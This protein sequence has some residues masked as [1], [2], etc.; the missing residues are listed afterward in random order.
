MK[1]SNRTMLWGLVG[2]VVVFLGLAYAAVPIYRAF[3]Q[4]TGFG[5]ATRRVEAPQSVG[6]TKS[7]TIRV[8]F[9][10]NIHD[11]DLD[12]RSENPFVDTPTGRSK[13]V[14]FHVTNRADHPVTVRATYNVGPEVMGPYFLKLQCFCFTNQTLAAH[15]SKTFPVVYYLDPKMFSDVDARLLRDVTLSY[16]FFQVGPE[17]A[18]PTKSP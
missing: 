6:E 13:M 16:T 17:G 9:D 18:A 7:A 11:V 1:L 4:A 5:G 10:T 14:Y 2:V 12:F 8:H 3:C 15:E